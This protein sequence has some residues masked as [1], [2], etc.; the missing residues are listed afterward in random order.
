M[1][2]CD[3]LFLRSGARRAANCGK[4]W[5]RGSLISG[6]DAQRFHA[7]AA[8]PPV[9]TRRLTFLKAGRGH[10]TSSSSAIA[11]ATTALFDVRKQLN[12]SLCS[13][14]STSTARRSTPRM[15][16]RRACLM[17]SLL[18]SYRPLADSSKSVHDPLPGPQK[19][20]HPPAADPHSLR[21]GCEVTLALCRINTLREHSYVPFVA[22]CSSQCRQLSKGTHNRHRHD[23]YGG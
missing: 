10:T 8:S 11:A 23:R 2:V 5:F 6:R 9:R 12:R 1:V 13:G 19:H 17:P 4:V 15:S 18:V 7:C 22:W 3:R 21:A 20:S 16:P 14:E